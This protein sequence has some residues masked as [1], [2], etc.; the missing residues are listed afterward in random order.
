MQLSYQNYKIK[1][2]TDFPT[3]EKQPADL[4]VYQ[5]FTTVIN[6]FLA[7]E[8]IGSFKVN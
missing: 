1:V 6:I 7:S 2:L 5:Y 8:G 3:G 4:L